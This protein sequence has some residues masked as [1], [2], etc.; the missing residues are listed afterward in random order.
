MGKNILQEKSLE[1]A[2]LCIEISKNLQ[3]KKEH[4]FADQIKRSATSVGANIAEAG[5]PQSRNDMISKFEIALKEAFETDHWLKV[6]K[7]ANLIDEKTF[8]SVNKVC[9]KIRVLLISSIKTL[10]SK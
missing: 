4:A 5:H 3:N 1:L 8:D 10:K 9:T 7:Q 6:F 2:S